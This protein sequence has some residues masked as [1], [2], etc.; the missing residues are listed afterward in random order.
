MNE[1][2]KGNSGDGRPPEEP[3]T[4]PPSAP[5]TPKAA[6]APAAKPRPVKAPPPPRP[7][8][9]VMGPGVGRL[10]RRRLGREKVAASEVEEMRQQALALQ[11][12]V[13]EIMGKEE[14]TMAEVEKKDIIWRQRWDRAQ[15]ILEEL[16]RFPHAPQSK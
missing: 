8:P 13:V 1:E 6:A 7:Q 16:A 12:Q 2:S 14:F 4:A 15:A 5:A 11:R 10:V 9:Q 3:K